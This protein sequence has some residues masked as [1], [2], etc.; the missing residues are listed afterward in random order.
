MLVGY[1]ETLPYPLILANRATAKTRLRA[2]ADTFVCRAQD[3]VAGVGRDPF[4]QCIAAKV[5]A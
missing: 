3:A 2:C 5:T 4:N 1:L